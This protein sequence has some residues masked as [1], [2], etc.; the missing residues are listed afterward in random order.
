MDRKPEL[1]E[2]A[3]AVEFGL[4]ASICPTR[5]AVCDAT[6]GESVVNQH[7]SHEGVGKKHPKTKPLTRCSRQKPGLIGLHYV[8]RFAPSTKLWS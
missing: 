3:I 1:E 7:P 6:E 2:E 5:S 4:W 8:S